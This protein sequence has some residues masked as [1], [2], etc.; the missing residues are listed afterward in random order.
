MSVKACVFSKYLHKKK[1]LQMPN[2]E[3]QF[4]YLIYYQKKTY[5]IIFVC[6]Y[7][8]QS[9]RLSVDTKI[10][11]QMFLSLIACACQLN[12]PIKS[13]ILALRIVSQLIYQTHIFISESLNS[14][15]AFFEGR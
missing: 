6:K 13:N 3:R 12:S 15:E 8:R 11:G 2:I 10:P 7:A 9:K 5:T 1:C 14:E 4:L